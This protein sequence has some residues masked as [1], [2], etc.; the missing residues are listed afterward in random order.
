MMLSPAEY[1]FI[2]QRDFMSFIER[3]FYELNPQTRLLPGPHIE[4]MAAKLEACRSY[5]SQLRLISR[6]SFLGR[7]L[8]YEEGNGGETVAWV[9]GATA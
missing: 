3:S 9:G 1:T 2:L 7:M 8:R 4:L 5:A 6:A